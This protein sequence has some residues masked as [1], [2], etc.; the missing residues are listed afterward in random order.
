MTNQSFQSN[1]CISDDLKST[2]HKYI[3]SINTLEIKLLQNKINYEFYLR[4]GKKNNVYL[5]YYVKL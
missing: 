4:H 2:V 5:D 1:L 3:I